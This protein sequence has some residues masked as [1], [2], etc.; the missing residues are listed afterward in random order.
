[1]VSSR[2][3]NH[4]AV[5]L[6]SQ[7]EQL[8]R[9]RREGLLAQLAGI[10]FL[11]RQGLAL[12]GHGPSEGNLNQLLLMQS[13]TN[14]IVKK[15]IKKNSYTSHDAV[16]E[17]ICIL[18][19][20]LLRT[21]LAKMKEGIGPTWY[22]IIADEA[23]DVVNSEQLNLSIRWVDDSYEIRE[24]PVGLFRVPDTKA[25]TLFTVIKDILL[26]CNLPLQLCRGQAYDG[27]A[28]MQGKISGVAT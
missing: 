2:E 6:N 11:A 22:S 26:R 14:V 5:Q 24:D 15:W 4:I 20:T 1:M 3:A 17:Q 13:N 19:Q 23:T 12:R 27:A 28:N 8:Q 25:E 10:R 16:T 7:M 18:G 21:L 9:D